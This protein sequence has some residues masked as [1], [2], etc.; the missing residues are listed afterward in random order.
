MHNY[1]VNFQPMSSA[2]DDGFFFPGHEQLR[3]CHAEVNCSAG[4]ALGAAVVVWGA[5]P[6]Q[7]AGRPQG[8]SPNL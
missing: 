2:R 3:C 1:V 4:A 6:L 8:L 5:A 7:G